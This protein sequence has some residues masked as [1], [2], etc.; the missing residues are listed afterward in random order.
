MNI[1]QPLLGKG[2]GVEESV[3]GLSGLSVFIVSL[4]PRFSLDLD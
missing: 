2:R 1:P 3:D 4:F